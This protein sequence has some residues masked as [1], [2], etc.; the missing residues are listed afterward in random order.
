MEVV[1]Q[2]ESLDPGYIYLSMCVNAAS[3]NYL[4]SLK[5]MCVC[6]SLNL[7]KPSRSM[8]DSEPSQLSTITNES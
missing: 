4:L 6:T 5:T 7:S 3:N 2:K 1:S 8:K